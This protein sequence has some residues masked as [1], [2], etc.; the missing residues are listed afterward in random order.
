MLGAA[1]IDTG[2]RA[3]EGC[4]VPAVVAAPLRP[5]LHAWHAIP[6]LILLQPPGVEHV[7]VEIRALHLLLV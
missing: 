5:P 7:L 2:D 1:G 4:S 6:A 3:S